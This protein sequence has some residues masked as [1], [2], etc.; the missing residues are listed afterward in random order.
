MINPAV[1]QHSVPFQGLLLRLLKRVMRGAYLSAA[2]ESNTMVGQ[3]MSWFRPAFSEADGLAW[4]TQ[5]RA[6][7]AVQQAH[8]FGVFDAGTGALLG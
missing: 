8:E 4:L 5:C 7:Q 3:W 1:K 6:D 2:Q